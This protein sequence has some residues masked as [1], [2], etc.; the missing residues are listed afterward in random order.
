MDRMSKRDI[1]DYV[2]TLEIGDLCDVYET[3]VEDS[4]DYMDPD[5]ADIIEH[6]EYLL[7]TCGDLVIHSAIL[8][9]HPDGYE[10]TTTHRY[11]SSTTAR[12]LVIT[13]RQK[14][15]EDALKELEQILFSTGDKVIRDAILEHYPDGYP[16]ER[17]IP[18]PP[19]SP[20]SDE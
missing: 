5:L 13:T 16:T 1:L 20:P 10:P 7:L 11:R 6:I 9:N 14:E 2:E 19:P 8:E 3:F 15:T 17:P 12:P 4:Y 18:T